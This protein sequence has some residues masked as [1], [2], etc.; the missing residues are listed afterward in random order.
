MTIIS[1][2]GAPPVVSEAEARQALADEWLAASP[3]DAAGIADFYKTSQALAAD[4]ETWHA[5]DARQ[6]WTK[7]VV[8][9]A[10]KVGAKVAVDIGCGAGHDLQ[11]L[12][13]AIEGMALY[14]VEPNQALRCD[15]FERL[16]TSHGTLG[17]YESVDICQ[18][19]DTADLL[20]CIDVLEHVPDPEAFLSGIARRARLGAVLVEATATHDIATPLHL[21]ANRGWHPGHCL[22]MAGWTLLE[23][24]DRVR[25]WQ[26]IA[27]SAVDHTALLLCAYRACS[28]QTMQSILQLAGIGWRFM[29]KAGDA[30][31]SRSRSQIVSTWHTQTADDVFLM[32]DDDIVFS[33]DDAER[34]VNLAR[35]RRSIAC[36]AYPVADG[37]STACRP[38]NGMLTF[39]PDE[40]PVEIE[41]A[42]T[43]FLACHRDVIDALAPTLEL[44]HPDQEWAF[45][46]YFMPFV[47][48]MRAASGEMVPAYLSEDWAFVLRARQAG[49]KIWLEP[50][51]RLSHLK[52]IPISVANMGVVHGIIHGGT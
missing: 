30:L 1:E 9:V 28:M 6:Q 17:I 42:S 26:R 8:Y 35:T 2:L 14:G 41:Y 39:G 19:I 45:R 47:A 3:S 43:G 44:T 22:E 18:P 16:R 33:P 36:A 52:E 7:M 31:I 20:V 37:S 13:D 32:V 10:Q 46:P 21:P 5:S 49:F 12:G 40:E 4:L 25:V 51:V 29:P 48:P 11:A 24:Q 50:T 27:P 38:L 34:V 15:V 23:A